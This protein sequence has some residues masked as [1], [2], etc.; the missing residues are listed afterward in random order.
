MTDRSAFNRALAARRRAI[1]ESLE[2]FL[3]SNSVS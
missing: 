1:V 3:R 2:Q